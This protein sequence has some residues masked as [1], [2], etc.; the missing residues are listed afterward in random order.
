MSEA[1]FR[2]KIYNPVQKMLAEL[3]VTKLDGAE[4]YL[5]RTQK[6]YLDVVNNVTHV[7]GGAEAGE[8][9]HLDLHTRV[10]QHFN[11]V[12]DKYFQKCADRSHSP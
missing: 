10:Q 2:A 1:D 4:T 12:A 7:H 3:K 11:V 9:V 6:V 8:G 5:P